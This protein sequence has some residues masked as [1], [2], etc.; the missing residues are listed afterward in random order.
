MIASSQKPD[1]NASIRARLQRA[2]APF[3]CVQSLKPVDLRYLAYNDRA[4]QIYI[5]RQKRIHA[6]KTA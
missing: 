2:G 4:F 5:E 3:D 6:R 1:F